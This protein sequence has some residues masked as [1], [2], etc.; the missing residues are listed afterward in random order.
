MEEAVD[1][2]WIVD[3]DARLLEQWHKGDLRPAILTEELAWQP[4]ADVAPLLIDMTA[5]FK[6]MLDK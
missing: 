4:R 3:L 5:Y 1:E 6:D 2:Y